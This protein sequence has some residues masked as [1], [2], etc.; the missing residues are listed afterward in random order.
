MTFMVTI[1]HIILKHSYCARD[2][3]NHRDSDRANLHPMDQ[4]PLDKPASVQSRHLFLMLH[5]L[6]LV[7]GPLLALPLAISLKVVSEVLTAPK[8]DDSEGRRVE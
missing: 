2:Y 4:I 6:E 3:N 5:P 1:R 8:I 7:D